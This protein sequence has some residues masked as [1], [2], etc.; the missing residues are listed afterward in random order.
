MTQRAKCREIILN[1][2]ALLAGYDVVSLINDALTPYE[3]AKHI[4][5]VSQ[6]VKLQ[7]KFRKEDLKIIIETISDD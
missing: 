6:F 4:Y 3:V 5:R 1:P 7:N 2:L